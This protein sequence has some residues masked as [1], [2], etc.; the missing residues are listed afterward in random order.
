MPPNPRRTTTD[1]L[2][3]RTRSIGHFED[4][5]SSLSSVSTDQSQA[6]RKEHRLTHLLSYLGPNNPL[7]KGVSGND[8]VWLLD[9]TAFRDAKGT[10]QAEF[11]A[12]AFDK[13]ASAKVLDLVGEIADKVGLSKGDEEEKTIEQRIA[14][15]V[16]TI[17]PGRQIRVK[18]DGSTHLKLGPGGRNGISSDIKVIPEPLPIG[19]VAVTTADVPVGVG[20]ML[21]MKTLFAEPEGWAVISGVLPLIV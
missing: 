20:G 15:F 7:P 16:M 19:S 10:W 21:E 3:S 9:N 2:E 8:I 4:T 18:V 17:L 12:A 11:V 6:S 14:P 13:Q 1:G 5:E